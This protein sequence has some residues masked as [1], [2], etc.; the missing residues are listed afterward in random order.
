MY[1]FVL[2]KT[3]LFH[4]K[5]WK[6]T[7][8]FWFMLLSKA[9]IIFSAWLSTMIM[10]RLHMHVPFHVYA[11]FLWTFV[12]FCSLQYLFWN[13]VKIT[14]N[15]CTLFCNCRVAKYREAN[16]GV[17]TIVTFPFL[18]AV[19]FGDWGHGICLLLGTLVL[20][21]REKKLASQV[22]LFD[23]EFYLVVIDC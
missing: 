13:Q 5:K 20:I 11:I 15:K 4:I 9:V 21:V 6:W 14:E 22:I 17:F 16:P 1:S 2:I 12:T 8:S 23:V 18:F 19:M 10:C 3:S 7:K